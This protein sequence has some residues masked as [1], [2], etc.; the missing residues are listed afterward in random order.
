MHRSRALSM[1]SS[2][3]NMTANTVNQVNIE[4]IWQE[5]VVTINIASYI[6]NNSKVEFKFTKFTLHLCKH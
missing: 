4:K 2:E 1:M 5:K 3:D 6:M